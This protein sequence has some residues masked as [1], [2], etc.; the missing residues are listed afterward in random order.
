ML[1]AYE[2]WGSSGGIG[3]DGEDK[4]NEK[5]SRIDSFR[6]FFAPLHPSGRRDRDE[7]AV[8]HQCLRF[9]DDYVLLTYNHKQIRILRRA[10]W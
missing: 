10:Q 1:W 9:P 5:S 2:V 6:H 4:A 8:K 3:I 7:E